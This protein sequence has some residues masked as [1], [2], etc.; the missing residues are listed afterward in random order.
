MRENP[1]ADQ[2]HKEELNQAN[3]EIHQYF[4][5]E[6]HSEPNGKSSEPLECA[7]IFFN[8]NAGG[9]RY[10]YEKHCKKDEAGDNVLDCS[11]S[12]FPMFGAGI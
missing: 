2:H 10:N 3:H 5:S 4:R 9:K 1:K 6:D 8:D 11:W 7:F 12:Y